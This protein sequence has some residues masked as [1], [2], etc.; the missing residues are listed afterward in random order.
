[1]AGF[2]GAKLVAAGGGAVPLGKAVVAP[3]DPQTMHLS[4]GRA[5]KP[6]GYTVEWHAVSV[7]TH[8]T[9]GAYR[10]TVAP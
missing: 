9:S 3:G 10:F 2:S 4:V 8:R 5:L 1:M 7:D 6:G